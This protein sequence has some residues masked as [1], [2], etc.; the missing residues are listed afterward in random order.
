MSGRPAW[1]EVDLSAIRDNTKA[2]LD[3]LGPGVRLMAVVKADGYG[4]GSVPVARASLAAGATWLGVAILDEALELREA[5]ITAPV[6][7]LGWTPPEDA[8][9]AVRS[10]VSLTVADEADIDAL[11]AAASRASGR[12]RVHLKVDTGMN[13][14][15]V[16]PGGAGLDAARALARAP[17]LLWE[18]TFTHFARAD[19]PDE[20]ATRGPLAR[21]LG[22]IHSVRQA[23]LDPGLL[24]A[25]NTAATFRRPESHL[26]MVRLG[27]GLYGYPPDP[28][29]GRAGRL[30]PALAVK[31]RLARV[32]PVPAGEAISYG[33]T[34]VTAEP[35]WIGTVPVGY[36]DGYR[37]SFGNRAEVLVGGSRRPV[38]GRVCMDQFMVG[39]GPAASP[40]PPAATG[41]EVVLLGRQGAARVT[42]NDLA[43]WAGTIPYEILTGWSRR[44]PRRYVDVQKG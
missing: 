17:H 40:S 14:L 16:R 20:A 43:A 5:G 34:Y 32:H 27:I 6:L 23:G 29:E 12:L 7:V 4:H 41:D 31:A 8:V 22:F 25:A 19:E 13:R 18:G 2:T 35:E 33:G 42:A 44:L 3:A 24:H 26:D 15:G 1:V 30:R 38:R 39:L 37:R 28:G 36:A 11:D 21:F 10:S 9:R